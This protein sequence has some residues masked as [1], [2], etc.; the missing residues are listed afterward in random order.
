MRHDT[1]L[2]YWPDAAGERHRLPE[3][4]DGLLFDYD[5]ALQIAL[6]AVESVVVAGQAFTQHWRARHRDPHRSCVLAQLEGQQVLL[7]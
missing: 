4:R 5:Q 2:A 6:D 1:R 7:H 3:S